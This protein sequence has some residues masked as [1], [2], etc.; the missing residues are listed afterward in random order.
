MFQP[1]VDFNEIESSLKSKLKVF[2]NDTPDYVHSLDLYP[3]S[4]E[5]LIEK[6]D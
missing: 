6:N 2:L 3:S 1:C 4:V 5:Y